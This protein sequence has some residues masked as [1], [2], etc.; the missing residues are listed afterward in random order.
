MA[1]F[2]FVSALSDYSY[3]NFGIIPKDICILKTIV[4]EAENSE[5]YG[6]MESAGSIA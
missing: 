3:N 5:Q 2:N 1:M 4:A 6:D